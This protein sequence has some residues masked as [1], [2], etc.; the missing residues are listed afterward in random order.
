MKAVLADQ[1]SGWLARRD[2]LQANWAYV[3]RFFDMHFRKAGFNISLEGF[4][5]LALSPAGGASVDDL[6][7]EQHLED[8][9]HNKGTDFPFRYFEL[10]HPQCPP[11]LELVEER[12]LEP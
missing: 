10:S 6:N 9:D 7:D 8:H 5:A 11:P 3:L 2:V 1:L 4:Q 12:A